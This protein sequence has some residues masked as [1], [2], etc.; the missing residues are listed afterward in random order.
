[1]KI[2]VLALALLLPATLMAAEQTVSM[3][4]SGNCG[5]CRKK[6]VKAAEKVDG[7]QEAEWNKKTKVFTATFDDVVTSKKS[8]TMA[9]LAA[10]YDV[11]DQKGDDK[12]YDNLPGC[13][14]YRDD[15]GGHD[16]H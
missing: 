13:C 16:D 7:V 11:E 5:S 4:V 14:Q 8:I 6:I 12:A 10:G 15:D 1:M 9:I 2:L 3:T